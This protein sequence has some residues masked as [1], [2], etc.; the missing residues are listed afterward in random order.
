MDT[1]PG[2][3]NSTSQIPELC[4]PI[5]RL[6]LL[7]V[8]VPQRGIWK[9]GSDRTIKSPKSQVLATESQP[10]F[11]DLPVGTVIVRTDRVQDGSWR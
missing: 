7:P 3:I 6:E 8:T 1:A 9:G 11:Q 2:A 10:Y 5:L 4:I